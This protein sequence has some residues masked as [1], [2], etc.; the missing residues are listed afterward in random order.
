[1]GANF[2]K[3]LGDFR[4]AP[5]IL[6]ADILGKLKKQSVIKC[7][8]RMHKERT[9]WMELRCVH[10]PI[11]LLNAKDLLRQNKTDHIQLNRL[12]CLSKCGRGKLYGKL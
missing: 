6:P 3:F 5:Q 7:V 12:H 9:E 4:F 2:L 11:P 1:M 10:L 8:H